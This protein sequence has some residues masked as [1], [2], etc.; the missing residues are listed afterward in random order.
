MTI[1]RVTELSWKLIELKLAYY[2]PD[3]LHD[4]WLHLKVPDGLYD[5]LE[6]EYLMLCEQLNLRPTATEMV[7][8][9]DTKPSGRLVYSKLSQPRKINKKL[10]F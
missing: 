2:R 8:F 4:D 5:A 9:D 3:L 6:D 10:D 7:G 1:E